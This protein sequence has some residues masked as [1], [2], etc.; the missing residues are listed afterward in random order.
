MTIRPFS[1]YTSLHAFLI[2]LF[3]FYLPVYFYSSGMSLMRII[4]EL[5]HTMASA[6]PNRI[7]LDGR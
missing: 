6:A 7:T 2:G 5:I 1:L 4:E 3:P